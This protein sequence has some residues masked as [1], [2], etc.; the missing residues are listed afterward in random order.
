MTDYNVKVRA[1]RGEKK[2]LWSVDIDFTTDIP[3]PAPTELAAE[4]VTDRSADITWTADAYATGAELSYAAFTPPTDLEWKQYDDG[5]YKGGIGGSLSTWVWGVMYPAI[6]GN[7]LTK[8]SIYESSVYNTEDITI[9]IYEG[10]D[11]EPGTLLYEETITPEAADA[12]HEIRLGI[13]VELTPGENLWVI[14]M[15]E[16]TYP[17]VGCDAYSEPN[18]TW[19]YSSGWDH[20][21]D[22]GLNYGWMIRAEVGNT[23]FGSVS[24][25]PDVEATSPYKLEGLTPETL[26]SVA[27][28]NIYGTEGESNW[29]FTSFV[30]AEG[31]PVPTNIAADL[32]ADGATLTWEGTADSYNVQYRTATG[33]EEIFYEGFEDGLPATWTTYS[34]NS[35]GDAIGGRGVDGGGGFVFHWTTTPPQYLITPELD[36]IRKGDVLR[37]YYRRNHQ[38]L[39]ESF[40]VGYSTTTN[41]VEAFTWSA[42]MT[43]S[44]N[45]WKLYEQTLTAGVKYIAIQCTSND[46]FYFYVDE[47][48]IYGAGRWSSPMAVTE[49]TATI[50]GLAT[51]KPYEYRIQGVKGDSPSEWS[52]AGEFALV[53]LDSSSD[54]T[55]LINSFEGKLAHVTLANR[56]LYK[57]DGW[58]AL[59]LPFDL[60][61]EQLAASP[62]ADADFRTFN[63]VTVEGTKATLSFTEKGELDSSGLIAGKPY[64]IQWANDSNIENPEFANVTIKSEPQPVTYKIGSVYVSFLGIYA[65]LTIVGENKSILFIGAEDKLFWPTAGTSIPAQSAYFTLWGDIEEIDIKEFNIPTPDQIS[66]Y[67]ENSEYSEDWYDLGGRKLAGKP[68]MKGIYVNG[69]RKISIK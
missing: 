25:S 54:N 41:D 24:W 48:G 10:G 59:T 28:R 60:S 50:S 17:M 1:I 40:M 67:S 66:E 33:D 16:G 46:K 65:P 64:I 32:A 57:D 30:T 21:T 22:Y 11:D 34:L 7:A 12:F 20:I 9:E 38:T 5:A 15:E 37:F 31:V 26:Y 56:I 2:S 39:T 42:E 14:L 36:D 55:D 13:P 35:G 8:V 58:N 62:L 3:F 6:T 29:T 23:D 51:N 63:G 44:E 27:V 4:N 18:N 52:D 49:P 68:S 61:P 69:G 45:D 47:I 19:I 53:T 43:V